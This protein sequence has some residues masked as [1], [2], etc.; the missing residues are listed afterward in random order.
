MGHS[1]VLTSMQGKKHIFF[2][3]FAKVQLIPYT[4]RVPPPRAAESFPVVLFRPAH[5]R[6]RQQAKYV[7]QQL[8]PPHVPAVTR[9][10]FTAASW[11]LKKKKFILWFLCACF[12]TFLTVTAL[13]MQA[14]GAEADAWKSAAGRV[15]ISA[16]GTL[17][18]AP[19]SILRLGNPAVLPWKLTPHSQ[20]PG[21]SHP[22]ARTPQHA[23]EQAPSQAPLEF[24]VFLL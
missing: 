24:S 16:P 18:A 8:L 20:T 19:G 15:G 2:F 17:W 12:L 21:S 10:L 14:A 7:Q 3:F 11:N 1:R 6:R 9:L 5:A 13:L 4:E 23:P 22:T